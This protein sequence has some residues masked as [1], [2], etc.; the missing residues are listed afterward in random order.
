MTPDVESKYQKANH[1]YEYKPSDIA[2]GEAERAFTSLMLTS[3][4]AIALRG[5]GSL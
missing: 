3:S 4:R 2:L 1:K 5:T